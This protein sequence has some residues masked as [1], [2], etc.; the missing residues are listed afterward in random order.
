MLPRAFSVCLWLWL[1]ATAWAAE[2]L[3]PAPKQYFNDYAHVVSP[4]TAQQLNQR[5]EDFEKQTSSQVLVAIFQKLPPN[6]ALEDY[7][8]RVAEAWKAGQRARDNGV[9]LF[10]F[11]QDRKLRIEVGYGLEGALPDAVAKRIIAEEIAPRFRNGDF[12]GGIT[13]GVNAILQ[14]I[15][16]EYQGTGRTAASGKNPSDHGIPIGFLIFFLLFLLFL[17]SRFRRRGTVYHRRRYPYWGGWGGWG[18]GWGGGGWGGGGWGGGGSS[19]G[20]FS[21]GGGRF[22]GGGASGGW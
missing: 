7:T 8:I 19:G 11:V 22:G 20:G 10:V 2:P 17:F 18:G 12:D 14:A 9:I 6:A 21:G 1:A 13:A 4:A 16:G 5:L 15:R 3:P